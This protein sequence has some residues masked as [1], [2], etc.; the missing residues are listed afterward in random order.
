MKNEAH[1]LMFQAREHRLKVYDNRD[2]CH[3]VCDSFRGGSSVYINTSNFG[4]QIVTA[5]TMGINI[6]PR[7]DQSLV[8]KKQM[9]R[10]EPRPMLY[11]WMSDPMTVLAYLNCSYSAIS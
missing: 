10:L 11:D 9:Q 1:R 7:D 8:K 4:Q 2:C 6:A 5:V 3:D